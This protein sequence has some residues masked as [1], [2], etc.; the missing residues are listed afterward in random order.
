VPSPWPK[1]MPPPRQ[2]QSSAAF[3]LWILTRLALASTDDAGRCTRVVPN[4]HSL[5]ICDRMKTASACC[6]IRCRTCTSSC[7]DSQC[8]WTVE[9]PR[10]EST[11]DGQMEA[12]EEVVGNADRSKVIMYVMIGLAA[13]LI[14]LTCCCLILCYCFTC[15]AGP[16]SSSVAVY[17]DGDGPR[18]A[19]RNPKAP[20]DRNPKP[21]TVTPKPTSAPAK[22][23]TGLNKS[24]MDMT[25]IQTNFAETLLVRCGQCSMEVSLGTMNS[26]ACRF[27]CPNCGAV[28]EFTVGGVSKAPDLEIPV[29][30]PSYWAA[31][32]ATDRRF[33]MESDDLKAGVQ[34]LFD[35]TWKN[36]WTRDRGKAM[37]VQRFE[38]VMVQRNENPNIWAGYYRLREQFRTKLAGADMPQFNVKT[39]EDYQEA[40]EAKHFISRGGLYQAVNEF[41]LFHGTKP[42]AAKTICDS[43]F[44]MKK[45]GSN[46]GTLYG[47]G[48]YFAEACSKADEYAT[49]DKDGIFAGLY[50][51]L[52]CRVVCGKLNYNA[53]VTPPVQE[54]VDSVVS[55]HTHHSI[56]GDR[57]KCRGTYREFIVFDRDQVYPEYVVIYRRVEQK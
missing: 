11:S 16:S 7:Q 10:A 4:D 41:Y 19:S 1:S 23:S 43:D 24:Q 15:F 17:M 12:M 34:A 22:S 3:L 47:P 36:Q 54:L 26:G 38:V 5:S 32:S 28:N 37:S 18:D 44:A 29:E 13:V 53:D 51:I 48:L 39:S 35:R 49:D 46:A 56:L 40:P 27:T 57:E 50:G 8:R 25:N 14:A 21:Y 45:A 42:S 9:A 6:G 55:E 31:K 52:I 20:A 30:Y 2:R 33:D